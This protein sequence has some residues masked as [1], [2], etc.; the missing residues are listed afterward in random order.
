MYYM[1]EVIF[2][3]LSSV[4]SESLLFVIS[5]TGN[6]GFPFVYSVREIILVL[7][8]VMFVES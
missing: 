4:D 3:M 8:T 1:S 6:V 5:A 2:Y 7:K